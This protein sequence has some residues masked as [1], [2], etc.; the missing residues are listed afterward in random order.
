MLTDLQMNDFVIMKKQHPCGSTEWK[1]VRLGAD[2][3]LECSGCGRRVM[4]T[5]SELAKRLKKVVDRGTNE[6]P[7]S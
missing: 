2:I 4:L 3:R 6:P 5:R 7:A 1:V